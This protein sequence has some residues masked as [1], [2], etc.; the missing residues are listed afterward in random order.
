MKEMKRGSLKYTPDIN[1]YISNQ[2]NISHDDAL[3]LALGFDPEYFH[4]Q[5]NNQDN[6][7]KLDHNQN[8][9]NDEEVATI[10]HSINLS[11]LKELVN[12]KYNDNLLEFFKNLYNQGFVF[13][14]FLQKFINHKKISLSLSSKSEFYRELQE[15]CNCRYWTYSNI[16]NLIS[17]KSLDGEKIITINPEQRNFLIYPLRLNSDNSLFKVKLKNDRYICIS[18]LGQQL[19]KIDNKG[20]LPKDVLNF[21]ESK[22]DIWIHEELKEMVFGSIHKKLKGKDRFK[23]IERNDRYTS[24]K[25]KGGKN[26]AKRY[27]ALKSKAEELCKKIMKKSKI[28]S[29]LELTK[30]VAQELEKN[31]KDLLLEFH[32]YKTNYKEKTDW[33]RPTFY[34]WCNN[35]FKSFQEQA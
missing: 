3:I 17:G 27:D 8:Y 19:E 31:H 14:E 26:S 29:G 20:Y 32:P 28:N 34:N 12:F 10:N 16:H 22:T 1:K 24:E 2:N 11:D 21:I 30:K 13:G 4:S 23:A 33:T 9:F 7:E 15:Y 18:K 25:R 5:I 6:Q 35:I